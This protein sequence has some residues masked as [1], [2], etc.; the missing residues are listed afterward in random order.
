VS[1]R[2][3]ALTLEQLD[4]RLR[5]VEALCEDDP[6]ESEDD[7]EGLTE[8][9]EAIGLTAAIGGAVLF[10]MILVGIL[11]ALGEQRN[12]M[13]IAT[14]SIAATSAAVAM[15]GAAQLWRRGT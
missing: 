6:N 8:I 2:T 1:Y 4:E 11:I 10:V 14:V 13:V 3:K 7:D 5:A 12:D 9:Q 15:W